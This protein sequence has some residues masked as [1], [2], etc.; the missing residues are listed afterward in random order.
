[1]AETE[2]ANNARSRT[3]EE[4]L[5]SYNSAKSKHPK[6]V[7][8]IKGNL[9]TKLE[10]IAVEAQSGKLNK[11]IDWYGTVAHLFG[12]YVLAESI[13]KPCRTTVQKI[14]ERRADSIREA[15]EGTERLLQ[16]Y[17]VNGR[18]GEIEQGLEFVNE[19]VELLCGR[20]DIL[21]KDS[22]DAK[23][24]L[25]LKGENWDPKSR[26]KRDELKDQITSYWSEINAIYPSENK[27][28][29]LVLPEFPLELYTSLKDAIKDK[30]VC[31]VT[32]SKTESGVYSFS[33][34]SFKELE[35]ILATRI[36]AGEVLQAK[37]WPKQRTAEYQQPVDS[38]DIEDILKSS[39]K[40]KPKYTVKHEK[41]GVAPAIKDA[42][43]EKYLIALQAIL[44]EPTPEL[45][46][47]LANKELAEAAAQHL[48]AWDKFDFES[49]AVYLGFSLDEELLENVRVSSK[50]TELASKLAAEHSTTL[51]ELVLPSK[52]QHLVYELIEPR[53]SKFKELSSQ[54]CE[55]LNQSSRHI[56]KA[57]AKLSADS[58]KD[59]QKIQAIEELN[60][61]KSINAVTSYLYSVDAKFFALRAERLK[62][63]K[64]IW[65]Y[66]PN[67]NW[68]LAMYYLRLDPAIDCDAHWEGMGKKQ[69]DDDLL[70]S[71]ID[72]LKF[73]IKEDAAINTVCPHFLSGG[74]INELVLGASEKTPIPESQ[75]KALAGVEGD[76]ELRALSEKLE[77]MPQDYR[78]FGPAHKLPN[79]EGPGAVGI[80]IEYT[81]L[82]NEYNKIQEEYEQTKMPFP[83]RKHDDS[84]E[85]WFKSKDV[86]EWFKHMESRAQK[87]LSML[88]GFAI[89]AKRSKTYKK[90]DEVREQDEMWAAIAD[91]LLL[92]LDRVQA[93]QGLNM[94]RK[95]NALLAISPIAA[96][97]YFSTITNEFDSITGHDSFMAF[98]EVE[99][100]IYTS[101]LQSYLKVVP[102]N[103]VIEI[104]QKKEAS[105][106]SAIC[107]VIDK[108]QLQKEHSQK[109]YEL[110]LPPKYRD[111][112]SED[113]KNYIKNFVSNDLG[114]LKLSEEK[115]MQ[116]A[117]EIKHSKWY[118]PL[119]DKEMPDSKLYLFFDKL[120]LQVHNSKDKSLPTRH[121]IEKYFQSV[122]APA[123]KQKHLNN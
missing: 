12:F 50:S 38:L 8:K 35:D 66:E 17:L 29:I 23:T 57:L 55:K 104:K 85:D 31:A 30:N 119:H 111:L 74:G 99:K 92:V 43:S 109:L 9:E 27:K 110:V 117:N 62:K 83:K 11:N 101:I 24:I 115:K 106:P 76:P 15:R 22:Q 28:I 72:D 65:P 120:F 122:C 97:A 33:K 44:A 91:N 112:L 10:Q 63:L 51:A 94:R 49:V 77:Q 40:K 42:V 32:Y 96:Y 2:K 100:Q 113:A 73:Y 7:E 18:L 123:L 105:I 37:K 114:I 47:L 60:K 34:V 116:L 80:E 93:H 21:A 48:K 41:R 20:V 16:D 86:I 79:L 68:I 88:E 1:M 84:S 4:F 87:Y 107:K 19:E 75:Y 69:D 71:I 26:A 45:D 36:S 108:Q 53:L 81:K 56:E 121:E 13:S 58:N 82:L 54:L 70:K 98:S 52:P 118:A 5:K 102:N 6:T 59:A 14:I 78:F 25:E 89:K 67:A 103:F 46:A 90:F 3:P 95:A 61:A 39:S 64:E